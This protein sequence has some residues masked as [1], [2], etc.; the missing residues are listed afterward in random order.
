MRLHMEMEPYQSFPDPVV[1]ECL[2]EDINLF[3]GLASWWQLTDGVSALSDTDLGAYSNALDHSGASPS[4]SHQTDRG[5]TPG[6]AYFGAPKFFTLNDP[7]G[8]YI[9]RDTPFTFGVWV[10]LSSN[11]NGTI[12]H[13]GDAVLGYELRYV[14]ID[15]RFEWE[16]TGLTGT[17][18]AYGD[19]VIVTTGVWYFVEASW[20]KLNVRARLRIAST[21]TP[22]GS[23]LLSSLNDYDGVPGGLA[24]VPGNLTIGFG[25][26]FLD[27]WITSVGFWTR[28]LTDCERGRLNQPFDYP[29][30]D[31]EGARLAEDGN[32]RLTEDGG[33][34]I[35]E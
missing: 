14:A 34:R 5:G 10:K 35:A 25:S 17:G 29:F 19:A 30:S 4:Y 11:V 15:H 23:P 16:I 2:E 9:T 18:L 31:T 33:I 8:F 1:L 12:I 26:A 24:E 3:T 6:A 7:S 32:L 22:Q 21:R 20:D 13:Y 27:G 28:L